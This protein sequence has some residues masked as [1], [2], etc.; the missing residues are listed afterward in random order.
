[1]HAVT[2]LAEALKWVIS[3]LLGSKTLVRNLR[4]DECGN[5]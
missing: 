4:L 5:E 1:M 2:V 3:R